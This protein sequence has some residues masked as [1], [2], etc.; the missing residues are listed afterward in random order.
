MSAKKRGLLGDLGPA[1]NK[2]RRDLVGRLMLIDQEMA[3]DLIEVKRRFKSRE[4]AGWTGADLGARIASLIAERHPNDCE[5]FTAERLR[6]WIVNR[7][8]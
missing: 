1:P 2:P 7:N 5:Y 8:S 4:L 3:N 6:N